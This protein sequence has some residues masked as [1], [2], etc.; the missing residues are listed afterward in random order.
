MT[1]TLQTSTPSESYAV[2][3]ENGVFTSH[4]TEVADKAQA[5]AK[6]DSIMRGAE[7]P[8]SIAAIITLNGKV[9]WHQHGTHII[10]NI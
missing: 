6:I 2:Q 8:S 1:A 10:T 3:W 7:W 4:P 5:F 9:V